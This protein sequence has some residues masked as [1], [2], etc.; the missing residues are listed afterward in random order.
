MEERTMTAIPSTLPPPAS[1]MDAEEFFAKY[2]SARMELFRGNVREMEMPHAEHGF[3]VNEFAFHL[4]AHVKRLGLGRVFGADTFV[5][6]KANP[7]TVYG[8]D[9]CFVSFEKMP[10]GRVQTRLDGIIPELVVEVR[11]PSDR[12]TVVLT[13]VLDYLRAGVL[14]VIVVNP[15]K[16]EVSVFRDDSDESNFGIEDTLTVHD[17]LPGFSLPVRT[18]FAGDDEVIVSE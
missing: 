14:A 17:V 13:K 8:M 7:D 18:L 3:I 6:V 2:E 9:L 4:T 10:R 15:A 16:Q 1:L 11:S 12:S 5:Q